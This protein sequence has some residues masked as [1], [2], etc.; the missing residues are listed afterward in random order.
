MPLALMCRIRYTL[1][2]KK[3][4]Q[5][6]VLARHMKANPSESLRT[7][8]RRAG[9]GHATIRRIL[10]GG[11]CRLETWGRI[12]AVIDITGAGSGVQVPQGA[13]LPADAA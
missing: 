1:G 2:M 11:D 4:A 7:L 5:Q 8:A 10:N 3:T 6:E 13:L 12:A 9:V